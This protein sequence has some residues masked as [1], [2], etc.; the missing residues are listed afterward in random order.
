[1]PLKSL[2]KANSIVNVY[3]LLSKWHSGRQFCCASFGERVKN[4][5]DLKAEELFLSAGNQ[6]SVSELNRYW[7]SLTA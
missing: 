1:V 5:G 2:L 3:S 7:E 4:L 6:N